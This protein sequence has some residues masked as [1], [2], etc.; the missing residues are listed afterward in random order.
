MTLFRSLLLML[1]LGV[2]GTAAAI[3]TETVETPSLKIQ[4]IDGNDW[5]LAAQR[6]TWVVINFWATWCS[7]CLAEMPDIDEFDQ[8]RDDVSVIGLAFEEIEL[9]D[10]RTFMKTHPVKYPI[11]WVDTWNPP[12]DFAEPRGLPTT[13]LIDPEGRVARQFIGPVTGKELA[14]A[15]E[16]AKKADTNPVKE[17]SADEKS[18]GKAAGA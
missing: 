14:Q 5:D 1:L 4:T 18:A 15:I 12:A 2:A 17:V 9:D 6:G 13:Y 3:T 16:T 7:P 10:L 11:A 8:S